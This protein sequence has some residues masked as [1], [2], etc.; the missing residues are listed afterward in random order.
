MKD[1]VRNIATLVLHA[2]S[3]WKILS[4][5]AIFSVLALSGWY[6]DLI[7]VFASQENYA[8]SFRATHGEMELYNVLAFSVGTVFYLLFMLYDYM[9]LRLDKIQGSDLKIKANSFMGDANQTIGQNNTNSPVV[10][11]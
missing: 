11:S 7:G 3:R 8:A 6:V 2:L 1:I 9:K 4:A 10:G 5:Y